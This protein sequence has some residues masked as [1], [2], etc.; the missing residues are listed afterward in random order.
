MASLFTKILQW[1]I[2]WEILYQDENI[3]A[4]KDIKPQDKTHILII[5]KHEYTSIKDLTW[6]SRGIIWDMVLVWNHLAKKFWVEDWYKLLLNAWEY[7]EVPHIHMHLLSS[8][9]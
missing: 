6:E 8:R 9:W 3:F 7:Q 2:P 1:E 5:P 4:I